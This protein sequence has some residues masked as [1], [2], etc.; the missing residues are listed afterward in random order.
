[1]L[2]ALY[3][4]QYSENGLPSSEVTGSGEAYVFA[5]GQYVSGTWERTELTD[6]F[7]LTDADGNVIN[8]P[9]GKV[10]ISLVPT[11]RGLEIG[12]EVTE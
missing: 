7:T 12:T 11:S 3:T 6:W 4:N 5:D 8:V 2:V 9:P 1:V 10:W